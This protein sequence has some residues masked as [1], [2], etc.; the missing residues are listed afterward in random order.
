M[1]EIKFEIVDKIGKNHSL[2]ASFI[3]AHGV[4]GDLG[5]NPGHT[6]L[7]TM[8]KPGAITIKLVSTE[9]VQFYASG[10]I[11]EIQPE[12]VTVLADT[13]IRVENINVDQVKKD[14]E[15]AKQ[16]LSKT[17]EGSEEFFNVSNKVKELTERIKF[18]S[19]SK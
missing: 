15:N 2:N 19:K 11:M 6:P 1:K 4:M 5:V 13:V 9:V 3:S 12:I 14:L 7:L 8:L 18:A 17:S 10:G 16:D